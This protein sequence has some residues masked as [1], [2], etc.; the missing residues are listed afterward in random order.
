M[1]KPDYPIPTTN[2][3]GLALL[4]SKTFPA[5]LARMLSELTPN[6]P[7]SRAGTAKWKAVPHTRVNDVAKLMGIPREHLLPE[8]FA[9]A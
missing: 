8:L 5:E 1:K 4:W 2:A 6:D 7:I 9:P 3:A